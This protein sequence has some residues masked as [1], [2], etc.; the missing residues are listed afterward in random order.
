MATTGDRIKAA[1]KLKGLTQKELADK[2]GVK[3]SA[4]HKYESG[5]I[6]N[7]KRDTIA[8][9]SD[10]LDVKPSYLLG[11]DDDSQPGYRTESYHTPAVFNEIR[12]GRTPLFPDNLDAERTVAEFELLGYEI[13]DTIDNDGNIRVADKRTS[14]KH[15]LPAS[16]FGKGNLSPSDRAIVIAQKCQ[17]EKDHLYGLYYLASERDQSIVWRIL[18]E[19]EDDLTGRN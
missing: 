13:D 17:E 3:Y 11:L 16:D 7:L 18:L 1:R 6:V 10:A 19:Y 14:E 4:I 12:V 15:L 5:L 9:L 8:K 2:V